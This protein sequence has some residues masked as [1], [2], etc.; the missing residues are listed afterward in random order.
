MLLTHSGSSRIVYLDLDHLLRW[1][2]N[3]ASELDRALEATTVYDRAVIGRGPHF[4][5]NNKLTSAGFGRSTFQNPLRYTV[6]LSASL[7]LEDASGVSFAISACS[8]ALTS[9]RF[10]SP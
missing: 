2:E 10:S 4:S 9:P 3:D 1:I 7:L 8:S 6:G 5:K